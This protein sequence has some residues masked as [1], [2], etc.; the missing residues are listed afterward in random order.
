MPTMKAAEPKKI[1]FLKAYDRFKIGDVI[2][3]HGVIA[4]RLKKHGIVEILGD[5]PQGAEACKILEKGK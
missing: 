5:G 1:R 4:E 2:V 3:H